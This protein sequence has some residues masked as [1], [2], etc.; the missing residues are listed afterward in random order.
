MWAAALATFWV[1]KRLQ[2][3]PTLAPMVLMRL[4][5][6]SDQTGGGAHDDK[7]G[8]SVITVGRMVRRHPPFRPWSVRRQR[9]DRPV[10]AWM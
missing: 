9:C 4:T 5:S 6:S 3:C 1:L 7:S 8:E 10:S 2:I